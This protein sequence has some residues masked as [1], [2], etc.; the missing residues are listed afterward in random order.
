MLRPA[1]LAYYKSSA[2]YKLLRLLDLSDVHAITP[3]SLKRHVHTF[4][5]V[6]QKR[7]FYLQAGNRDDLDAWVAVLNETRQQLLSTASGSSLPT[8][9]H[10]PV[11]AS[12]TLQE[13]PPAPPRTPPPL[14][15][16]HTGSSSESDEPGYSASPIATSKDP[17][18]D[19]AVKP[20]LSGYLMKCGSKRRN[21][22]K[23]WFVL[24]ADK[25]IY[26]GSHMV[27]LAAFACC[28]ALTASSCRTRNLTDKSRYQPFSMPSN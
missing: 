6:T 20:V 12:S 24:T 7:T 18:K 14:V 16:Q 15:E 5:I 10:T 27:C 28:C 4:G 25:L 26:S 13:A 9:I 11:T 2:E 8:P 19:L 22:R 1:H 21:W 17:S 23:R 3:I